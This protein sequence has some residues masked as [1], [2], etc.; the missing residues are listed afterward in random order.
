MA[1]L[2]E[3]KR[4][5]FDYEILET[6]E[7][8]LEL[9]GCE[10]KSVR[11]HHGKL[12]GGHVTVRGGEAFLMNIEIPPYQPINTE[13]EYD[14]TRKR[15]LLLNKKEIVQLANAEEERGLTII[16]LRM[17]TKGRLLKIA[18]AIVRGKKKFDK[19]ESIKKREHERDIA[20]EI[21]GGR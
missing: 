4:A 11:A 13:K 21:K 6:F 7:A 8:G 12:E 15:R 16:P 17:Y 9:L 3:H 2:I 20:R 14:A 5:N 10:V 19:R 1:N 18:I